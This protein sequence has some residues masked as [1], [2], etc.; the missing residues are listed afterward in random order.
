MTRLPPP[1]KACAS[2]SSVWSTYPSVL[3]VGSDMSCCSSRRAGRLTIRVRVHTHCFLV[4]RGF[5]QTHPGPTPEADT[6]GLTDDPATAAT[7]RGSTA[8][9]TAAKAIASYRRETTSLEYRPSRR[10]RLDGSG[11][12]A[13][14][15]GSQGRARHVPDQGVGQGSSRPL[16]DKLIGLPTWVA[17]RSVGG[18]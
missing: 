18:R 9:S 12:S 15:Y 16:A 14:A 4:L 1:T 8:A 10:P 11:Q 7:L 2:P 5:C 13:H 17:G 3:L 6:L